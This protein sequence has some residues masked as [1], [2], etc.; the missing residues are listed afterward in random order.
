MAAVTQVLAEFAH[1]ESF[2][3]EVVVQDACIILTAWF[4]LLASI[5]CV[6]AIIAIPTKAAIC[7]K[8]SVV[9][10]V[11]LAD[12]TSFAACLTPSDS[13]LRRCG[14]FVAISK[15]RG[16]LGLITYRA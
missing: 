9:W 15:F 4:F 6:L 8:G 7:C 12:A 13:F 16:M 11:F 10:H 1:Q 14:S 5:A 3:P 2:V